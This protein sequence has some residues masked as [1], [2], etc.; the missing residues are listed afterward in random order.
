MKKFI[1]GAIAL[2]KNITD[3]VAYEEPKKKKL[4]EVLEWCNR[5]NIYIIF[6][7]SDDNTYLCEYKIVANTKAMCNGL[8]KE[9]EQMLKDF[10]PQVK[11]LW[12][13]GGSQLY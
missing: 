10:F 6:G 11:S 5:Y 9:L 4:D 2:D 3:L 7:T 12:F 13:A 8:K 1:K